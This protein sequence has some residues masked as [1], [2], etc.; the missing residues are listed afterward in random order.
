MLAAQLD[1]RMKVA[2]TTRFGSASSV[3]DT[4]VGMPSE[5]LD[6]HRRAA[7]HRGEPGLVFGAVPTLGTVLASSAIADSI[8]TG[9]SPGEREL[10]HQQCMLIARTAC[11]FPCDDCLPHAARTGDRHEAHIVSLQQLDEREQLGLTSDHLRPRSAPAPVR[12]PTRP[13]RPSC[14]VPG[15]SFAGSLRAT[16]RATA[17]PMQAARRTTF[18]FAFA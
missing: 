2:S 15:F 8:P 18:C 12:A 5:Q 1:G 3:A 6:E 17:L 14:A 7:R 9:R 13:S 4:A 16:T 11:G 10:L